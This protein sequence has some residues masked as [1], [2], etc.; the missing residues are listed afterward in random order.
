[1]QSDYSRDL[2]R[3]ISQRFYAFYTNDGKFISEPVLDKHKSSSS[4]RNEDRH[5]INDL[6]SVGDEAV[7]FLWR[8]S[9]CH[10]I[11]EMWFR[12]YIKQSTSWN[13][14]WDMCMYIKMDAECNETTLAISFDEFHEDVMRFTKMTSNS[15]QHRF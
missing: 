10:K 4:K 6:Q 11:V 3:S 9:E 14:V 7:F 15:Y 13:H 2:I 1:M 5:G 12:T 8:F